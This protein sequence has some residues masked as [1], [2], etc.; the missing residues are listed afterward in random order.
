MVPRNP[1]A[2]QPQGFVTVKTRVDLAGQIVQTLRVARGKPGD[3]PPLGAVET[4][5]RGR[6]ARAVG[7]LQFLGRLLAKGRLV[8]DGAA[9]ITLIPAGRAVL[10]ATRNG[11]FRWDNEFPENVVDVPAFRIDTLP[12]KKWTAIK[13]RCAGQV[14]SLLELLQGKL[15]DHVMEVV[16]DREDG[17]FP[18]PREI[19]LKCD[20]PDWAVMC[21][22]VAAVLYGVG[23]RLDQRP[24][25]LFQLRGVDH[26][27]LISADAEAA[28]SAATSRGT[29][30][31]LAD[32]MAVAS[33][34]I[35]CV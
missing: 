21:K 9:D 35:T 5:C 15:S 23:A 25:L 24:E 32:A 1:P 33:G 2:L 10:G 31:R 14:G 19:S 29:S 28:V 22:H 3:V 18:L 7:V 13:E 34:G 16:T 20:C 4:R 17:L 26:E 11:R 6:D 30:K 27:D 12:A 8:A